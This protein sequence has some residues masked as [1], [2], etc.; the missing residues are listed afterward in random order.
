MAAADSICVSLERAR[1]FDP[2]S[3]APWDVRARF[4]LGF[5]WFSW[6]VGDSAW[7]RNAVAI[8]LLLEECSWMRQVR[9]AVLYIRAD[10][11]G[12][13]SLFLFFN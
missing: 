8:L 1:V 5:G 11:S 7:F 2:A 12:A 9:C 6:E 4:L 10:G 13:I 3:S